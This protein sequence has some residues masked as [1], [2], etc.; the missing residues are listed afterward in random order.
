MSYTNDDLQ[1]DYLSA[2]MDSPIAAIQARR[3][4]AYPENI[5]ELY[6][7]GRFNEVNFPGFNPMKDSLE[8]ILAG[9]F[10]RV[11]QETESKARR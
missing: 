11:E 9:M 2:N 8:A 7:E 3:L 1:I 5:A 10:G 6:K 4:A